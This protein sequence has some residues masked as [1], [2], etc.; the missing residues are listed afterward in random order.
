MNAP[1]VMQAT[2]VKEEQLEAYVQK[3]MN[4]QKEPSSKINILVEKANMQM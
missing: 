3:D 4:V 2:I 1:L